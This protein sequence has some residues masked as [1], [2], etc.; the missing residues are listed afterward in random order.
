MLFSFHQ[1]AYGS[2]ALPP[3]TK[4]GFCQVAFRDVSMALCIVQV[5]YFP[6]TWG[7]GGMQVT[8]ISGIGKRTCREHMVCNDTCTTF[9]ER[10]VVPKQFQTL[11]DRLY[12]PVLSIHEEIGPLFMETL[13][14]MRLSVAAL[15][16]HSTGDV[17]HNPIVGFHHWRRRVHP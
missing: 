6:W 1:L 15:T 7:S 16:G 2:V 12:S 3:G 13:T 8:R 9:A 17:G 5:L 14:L 4:L 11:S 10:K